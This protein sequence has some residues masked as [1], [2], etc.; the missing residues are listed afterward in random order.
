MYQ[1]K[2][3]TC[4]SDPNYIE[5]CLKDVKSDL[6]KLK[7]TDFDIIENDIN[8]NDISTNNDLKNN[9]FNFNIN[10]EQ[11]SDIESLSSEIDN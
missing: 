9:N 5:Q 11:I 8:V 3:K 2:Y 7:V 4:Y 1:E 6:N 10:N